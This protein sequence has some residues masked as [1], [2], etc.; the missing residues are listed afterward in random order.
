MR[1]FWLLCI[2]AELH[3]FIACCSIWIWILWIWIWIELFESIS[4]K[5]AKPFFSLSLFLPWFQPSPTSPF[6][7]NKEIQTI[8][9]KFKFKKIQTQIGQQTIKQWISAWM[10]HKQNNLNYFRRQPI[11]LFFTKFPV[12][13]NKCWENFKIVR[14]LLFYF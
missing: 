9:F 1:S 3:C 7:F 5:N 8:Q 6:F 4:K 12:K 10:Q 13:K 11:I 14:K 2:H